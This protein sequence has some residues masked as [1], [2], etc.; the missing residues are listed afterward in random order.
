MPQITIDIPEELDKKIRYKQVE[1]NAN[2]R[3]AVIILLKER[4]DM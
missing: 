1:Y 3:D 2:K 4:F